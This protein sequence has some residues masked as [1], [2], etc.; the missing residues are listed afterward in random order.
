MSGTIH[1]KA[2]GRISRMDAQTIRFLR[3][4]NEL[5]DVDDIQDENFTGGL[6]SEEYLERIRNGGL[7]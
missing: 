7:S 6:S 3:S 4:S 5:P 1:F 2:L